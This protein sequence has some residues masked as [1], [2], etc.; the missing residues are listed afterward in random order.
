M[1]RT[2]LKSLLALSGLSLLAGL[3]SCGNAAP[4]PSS[5]ASTPFSLSLSET[6][7]SVVLG[8][9]FRLNAYHQT[10]AGEKE[11]WVSSDAS[12]AS[13]SAGVVKALS[14]GEA[15]IT[16]FYA[17]ASASCLVK[18]GYGE[19][20]PYLL[21]P[22]LLEDEL[23]LSQGSS[24]PI[25]GS[26][27]FNH[28]EYPASLKAAISSPEVV[29]FEDGRLKAKSIGESDVLLQA[30]WHDFDSPLLE[31]K[32]HVS[33]HKDV[34]I[35]FVE[36]DGGE[37]DPLTSL[38]LYSTSSWQGENYQKTAKVSARAVVN[39]T[40]KRGLSLSLSNEKPLKLENETLTAITKGSASLIAT[41]SDSTGSYSAALPITVSCPI[42]VYE[43]EET[44]YLSANEDFPVKEVFGDG[45]V[46]TAAKQ[47]E[48]DL[49]VQEGKRLV[50]LEAEG[51]ASEPLT[52]ETDGGGFY[53]P[54]VFA[55]DYGVNQENAKDLLTLNDKILDGYYYLLE[56]VNVDMSGQRYSETTR[57][58]G[59]VFDGG[60]H[61]F[62]A[63]VGRDGLFGGV[64][65]RAVIK[66]T[67]FEFT[68]ASIGAS[69]S[70]LAKN[71]WVFDN[72]F[73]GQ[74]VTLSNLY[75]TTT[76]FPQGTYALFEEKSRQLAMKDVYVKLSGT[77]SLPD[78]TDAEQGTS[79]LFGADRATMAGP[80]SFFQGGYQNVY[81]VSEKW[82]PMMNGALNIN[83]EI[84]RYVGYARNDESKLGPLVHC[85][86]LSEKDN[87]YCVVYPTKENETKA[88]FSPTMPS[89]QA[90]FRED[91]TAFAWLYASEEAYPTGGI[92][93]YDSVQQLLAEHPI[94]RIGSWPV[95]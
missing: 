75:I 31:R 90:D 19:D 65:D 20:S 26:V 51:E 82:M 1:K 93:R 77:S 58:F 88:Y 87:Q 34:S 12:V 29:S 79:A 40:E 10:I 55:Y 27:Y 53:F 60:G 50:G 43:N 95:A 94:E 42:A 11:E 91:A 8:D 7:K 17:G 13:V 74:M 23:N 89:W 68:F 73:E 18:V 47:G 64:S 84:W 78:Y 2:L 3:P 83:G 28:Q 46:I 61:T 6:D 57:Y 33:V 15:T 32:I 80:F 36:E 9:S 71:A 38:T 45:A 37:S 86:R 16:V 54:S 22:T 52:I 59:G 25:E 35:Y 39:G 62:Q 41:Y 56:D 30:E 66:N 72:R 44:L 5:S 49:V 21:I 67:H 24:Y 76:N 81:V 69:C 85:G 14:P 92:F 48:R 70:G 63:K 4:S